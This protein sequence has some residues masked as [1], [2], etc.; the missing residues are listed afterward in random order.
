MDLDTTITR[1]AQPRKK[2]GTY[3]DLSLPLIPKASSIAGNPS[4]AALYPCLLAA[5]HSSKLAG[6]LDVDGEM[7]LPS[8]TMPLSP[9][10]SS[11]RRRKRSL[12]AATSSSR[13]LQ[14]RLHPDSDEPLRR[15]LMP[16][17]S[18]SRW[19]ALSPT[20]LSQGGLLFLTYSLCIVA[21]IV[22]GLR[23]ELVGR[24]VDWKY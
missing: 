1:R 23:T 24:L 21:C 5:A 4:A 20:S 2:E 7:D 18:S 13:H 22:W 15:T 16:A 14:R 3:Q 11:Q 12:A 10:P 6:Q 19:P 9:I 17:P 8:P